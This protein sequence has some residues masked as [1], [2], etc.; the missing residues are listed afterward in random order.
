MSLDF[1]D[2]EG[3]ADFY[4]TLG[5]TKY[6]VVNTLVISCSLDR[7]TAAR[8]VADVANYRPGGNTA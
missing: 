5:A 2:P 3:V 7:V 1:S 6:E 8:I 4:L